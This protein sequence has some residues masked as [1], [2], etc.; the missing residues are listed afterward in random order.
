[1]NLSETT[2]DPAGYQWILQ[3]EG[4]AWRWKAVGRDD[5][6]ILVEGVAGTRA[7]GAAFLARAISLGIL[8]QI[9]AVAA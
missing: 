2:M 6:A 9:G 5:G 3:P 7:E 4:D 1:L 8:R